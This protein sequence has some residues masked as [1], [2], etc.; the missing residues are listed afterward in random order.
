MTRRAYIAT[1]D[2]YRAAQEGWNHV[3]H[4]DPLAEMEPVWAEELQADEADPAPVITIRFA[5]GLALLT[6]VLI[7]AH[8]VWAA[9]G[10]PVL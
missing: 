5:L 3:C 8:V 9:G 10:M 2:A 7:G 1:A 6:V 4:S